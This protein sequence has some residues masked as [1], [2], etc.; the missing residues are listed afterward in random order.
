[1][2]GPV[3]TAVT[4]AGNNFSTV[5]ADNIVYFGAVQAFVTAAT[6]TSL[7]VKVPTGATYQPITVTTNRLVA[8]D[9]CYLLLVYSS[10][11]SI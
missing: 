8:Y 7:T 11:Y 3:G 5:A 9:N 1:M 4:I 10:A 2:S 6:T